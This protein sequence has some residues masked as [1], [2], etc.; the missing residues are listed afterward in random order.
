MSEIVFEWCKST[1]LASGQLGD[2][3][4]DGQLSATAYIIL[5]MVLLGIIAGLSWC[6]YRAMT[7]GDTTAEPQFRD[8][9][10]DEY[11]QG[12]NQS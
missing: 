8:E 6:F 4:Y 1:S 10:G 2:V 3:V 9:I 5:S 12:P 11:Q 7:A